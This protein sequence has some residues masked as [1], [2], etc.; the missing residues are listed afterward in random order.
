MIKRLALLLGATF[1]LTVV[2]VMGQRIT[3]IG[4]LATTNPGPPNEPLLE[5]QAHA[6]AIADLARK[7]LCPNGPVTAAGDTSLIADDD[8]D[9]DDA[10]ATG[11]ANQADA[12]ANVLAQSQ[13]RLGGLVD[14]L[15]TRPGPPNEHE[16]TALTALYAAAVVIV[17][18]ISPLLGSDHSVPPSPAR[19]GAGR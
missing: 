4:E 11:V 3:R 13:Q 19:R 8:R 7:L 10:S 17:N 18:R 6:L 14:A 5:A 15:R 1:T 9:A 16:A 12:V 2:A